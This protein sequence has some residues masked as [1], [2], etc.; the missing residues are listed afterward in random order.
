LQGDIAQSSG[1]QS[2][3]APWRGVHVP[4]PADEQ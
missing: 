3:P 1:V 2:V 4:P